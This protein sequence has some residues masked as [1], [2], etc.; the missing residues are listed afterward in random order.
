MVDGSSIRMGEHW[1][2]GMRDE[3]HVSNSHLVTFHPYIH[4][5]SH[6]HTRIVY[7]AFL[8]RE[9]GPTI[10]FQLQQRVGRRLIPSLR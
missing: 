8:P 5:F 6:V 4:I 10:S 7:P 1:K 2:R 9:P 3:G